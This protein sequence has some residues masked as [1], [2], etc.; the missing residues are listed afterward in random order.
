MWKTMQEYTEHVCTYTLSN[1]HHGLLLVVGNTAQHWLGD[2]GREAGSARFLDT[3]K[4]SVILA[5]D[6][7]D[8]WQS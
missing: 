6:K 8:K 7:S 2:K 4:D 3:Y 1:L 5:N